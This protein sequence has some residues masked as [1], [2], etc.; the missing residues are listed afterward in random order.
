MG[1]RSPGTK[2]EFS[3]GERL[4]MGCKNCT[5]NDGVFK[6]SRLSS[7]SD[8]CHWSNWRPEGQCTAGCK[9]KPGLQK[10]VRS[11]RNSDYLPSKACQG[12]SVKYELCNSSQSC[13]TLC[14]TGQRYNEFGECDEQCYSAGG[15]GQPRQRCP[16]QA[17]VCARGLVK[18]GDACV[19][20]ADCYKCTNG[21]STLQD[22]GYSVDLAAC[23]VVT[24]DKGRTS[25]VPLSVDQ[26]PACSIE[27]ER[28]AQLMPK[29]KEAGRCCYRAAAPPCRRAEVTVDRLDSACKLTA[30]IRLPHCSGNC[31]QASPLI[32]PRRLD[33]VASA[34]QSA[35]DGGSS[36]VYLLELPGHHCT[37]CTPDRVTYSPT[38]LTVK[39]QSG[40]TRQ[41]RLPIVGSC[42]CQQVP[43]PTT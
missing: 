42:R 4:V 41:L 25:A 12:P 21:N 28:M 34:A 29:A 40:E 17:C 16:E 1:Q 22:G 15:L 27:D 7:C 10:F 36:S 5:C 23:Q 38:P 14:P 18:R 30:P 19:P 24:C 20:Q 9:L 3:P 26:M 11:P 2:E 31:P 6:C 39:C 13:D 32:A 8:E 37:G 35:S 33:V 43:C